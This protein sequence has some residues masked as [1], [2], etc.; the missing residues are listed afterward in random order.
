MAPAKTPKTKMAII[1]SL[2]MARIIAES[3][4]LLSGLFKAFW[5]MQTKYVADHLGQDHPGAVFEDGLQRQ[6]LAQSFPCG[7]A[8]F[9]KENGP[10]SGRGHGCWN[11]S[12]LIGQQWRHNFMHRLLLV[13]KIKQRCESDFLLSQRLQS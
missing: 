6:S 9:I 13:L 5:L 1:S 2:S 12:K 10:N 4:W 7:G 8:F 11:D 3:A